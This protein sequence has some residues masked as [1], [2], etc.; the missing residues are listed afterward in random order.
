MIPGQ[1]DSG[2]EKEIQLRDTAILPVFLFSFSIICWLVDGYDMTGYHYR[3]PH[4]KRFRW[5]Q[6]PTAVTHQKA[7]MCSPLMERNLQPSQ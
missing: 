1:A 5:K 7:S 3:K 6:K 4:L 2:G